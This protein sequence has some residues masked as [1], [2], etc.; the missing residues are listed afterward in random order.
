MSRFSR[1]RI[2]GKFVLDFSWRE[3]SKKPEDATDAPKPEGNGQL[4]IG[5]D[6][7]NFIF[8]NFVDLEKHDEG[9]PIAALIAVMSYLHTHTYIHIIC[10]VMWSVLCFC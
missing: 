9:T 10:G 7:V 4:W 1:S 6:Y 8:K 5:K 3:M 2:V